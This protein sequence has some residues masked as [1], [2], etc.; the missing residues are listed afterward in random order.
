M[1]RGSKNYYINV[2]QVLGIT[3]AGILGW[4]AI[5]LEEAKA[6]IQHKSVKEVLQEDVMRVHGWW[7]ENIRYK[8]YQHK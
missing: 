2:G 6:G 3:V 7:N 4:K 8:M 1:F 5:R